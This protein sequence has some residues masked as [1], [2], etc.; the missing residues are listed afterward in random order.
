MSESVTL[1]HGTGGFGASYFLTDQHFLSGGI[2]FSSWDLPFEDVEARTGFGIA[3][4]AGYE[5]APNWTVEG[6]ITWG[7]PSAD[8]VSINA[9]SIM[10]SF[11][12][13]LY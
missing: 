8:F 6:D 5:V 10:V 9:L 3:L 7:N 4:G 11:N 12:Y 2:G 13:L 1:T